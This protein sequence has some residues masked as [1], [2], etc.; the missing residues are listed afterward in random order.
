M[1]ASEPLR[2]G[3]LALR[4]AWLALRPDWLGLRPA[5]LALGPSRGGW[6]D[7]RTDRRTENLPILQDFVPYWGRC[8]KTDSSGKTD[9]HTNKKVKNYDGFAQ[10]G[11]IVFLDS[12]LNSQRDETQ[13]KILDKS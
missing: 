12:I 4:P 3:W 6:T 13:S 7:G 11:I 5:W 8:P 2:P 9:R 1:Q 10:I